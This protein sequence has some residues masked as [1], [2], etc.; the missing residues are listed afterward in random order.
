MKDEQY[1][2][3]QTILSFSPPHKLLRCSSA[4]RSICYTLQSA[5]IHMTDRFLNV[6]WNWVV[7]GMIIVMGAASLALIYLALL[8]LVAKRLDKGLTPLTTGVA[9]GIGVYLL[10]RHRDDLSGVS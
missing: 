2:V 7:L 1:I 9:L 6:V 4:G 3:H 10:L 8:E 5:E